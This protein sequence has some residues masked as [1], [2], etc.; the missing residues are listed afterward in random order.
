MPYINKTQRKKY[1]K[2]EN[3]I[4]ESDP[5][6]TK[7]DLEYLIFKLMRKYMITRD[8]RYTELHNCV[9]AVQHC[10]DE[11]RRRFLDERENEARKINGD[12]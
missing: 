10:A 3:A 1:E 4:I 8:Y 5:I 2:I 6:E 7:G 12:V 9:Y 11:F